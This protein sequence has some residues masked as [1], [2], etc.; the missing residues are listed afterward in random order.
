MLVIAATSGS[1]ISQSWR[2][3][4]SPRIAISMTRISVSRGAE[5]SDNGMPISV[6]KFSGLAW[7]RRG[8][9]A[10]VMSLTDVLPV[11]PVIPTNGQPIAR[12]QERAIACRHASGS[13]GR[14][15][16]GMAGADAAAGPAGREVGGVRGVD[17]DAP[18][19]GRDRV[20]GE[21][22][23]VEMLAGETEE[24]IA[25]ADLAGVDDRPLGEFLAAA[26]Y[27]L[28]TALGGEAIGRQV[29]H[30]AAPSARNS[31]RATS[32]SSKGI[33]RPSSNS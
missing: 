2:I 29:D 1:A 20:T 23:T 5:S 3:W 16:P 17:D 31:S 14:E 15:D 33:L 19:A 10:L 28:R 22:A 8:S 25:A 4:P 13:G 32:R 30:A 21:A 11:D 24:E 12:R 6:L 18:G 7:T 27:D 26:D 9:S